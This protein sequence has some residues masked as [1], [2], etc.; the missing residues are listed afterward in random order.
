MS[1]MGKAK[2]YGRGAIRGGK[3]AASV[4][5]RGN[6]TARTILKRVDK[7]SGGAATKALSGNAYGRAALAGSAAVGE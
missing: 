4:V 3:K 6:K 2:K 1:F 5:R 7:L